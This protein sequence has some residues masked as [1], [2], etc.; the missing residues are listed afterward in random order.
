MNLN[1][2]TEWFGN[3][4]QS[5]LGSEHGTQATETIVLDTSTFTPA[6]HY[7]EGF[8]KSGI[9]LGQITAGGKYGPYDGAATDGREVLVGF[10]YSA[11]GAPTVTTIDP[12]GAL[13]THGKVRE[14]RLPVSV[15]AAGKADVVGS[16]RFV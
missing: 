13:F 14:S 12:A 4:D 9:P 1:Q 6:T 16:I 2:T 5:W 11:V 7:P 8:F 10:L 3:D 15:D